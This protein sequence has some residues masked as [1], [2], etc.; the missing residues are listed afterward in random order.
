MK[1]RHKFLRYRGSVTND[2]V[3][4]R[5]TLVRLIPSEDTALILKISWFRYK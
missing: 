2:S 5:G 3:C 1:T 4:S